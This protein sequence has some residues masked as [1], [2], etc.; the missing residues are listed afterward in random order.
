MNSQ[1]TVSTHVQ[2]CHDSEQKCG[3]TERVNDITE[4]NYLDLLNSWPLKSQVKAVVCQAADFLT[5]SVI[6]HTN[7]WNLSVLYECY[8]FL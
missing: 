8:Q 4:I 7:D 5:V 3:S 2:L 1:S 6:T